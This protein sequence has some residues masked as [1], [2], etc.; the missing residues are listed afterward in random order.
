M[1]RC[2]LLA[3]QSNRLK[4]MLAGRQLWIKNNLKCNL[5]CTRDFKKKCDRH[6]KLNRTIKKSNWH[7]DKRPAKTLC[8][9]LRVSQPVATGA[10][11]AAHRPMQR[12]RGVAH[13]GSQFVQHSPLTHLLNSL[14]GAGQDRTGSFYQFV[15]FFP[16]PFRAPPPLQH[17]TE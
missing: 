15:Y 5:K 8:F 11:Q 17:T 3:G 6:Y 10:F 1:L 14:Q 2:S 13:D 12:V 16:V 9:A 4:Q 7:G